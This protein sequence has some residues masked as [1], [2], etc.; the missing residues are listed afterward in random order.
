MNEYCADV[1]T[2]SIFDDPLLYKIPENLSVSVGSIVKVPFGK[3]Y[4]LGIVV[5]VRY[6]DVAT[7][8]FPIKEINRVL[9][10]N[11]VLGEDVIALIKWMHVYY[12]ATMKSLIETV[13]PSSIR[14]EMPAGKELFLSI[15]KELTFDETENLKR[16]SQKQYKI[17]DMVRQ[18]SAPIKKSDAVAISSSAC[19]A[20]IEKSYLSVITY[21]I[22]RSFNNAFIGCDYI[23]SKK[24]ILSDEQK[25]ASDALINDVLSCKFVTHVLHGVTGSG[26]TEVYLKVIR[27]VLGQNGQVIYLVPELSLTPQTVARIRNSLCLNCDEIVIWHSGLSDGERRDAW[28]AMSSGTARIV[29]GARS[30]IF[31]PF[32][33]LRLIIVDEE[34]ETTYKQNEMPRYNARDVAVYRAKL[35]NAVCILGSATPSLESLY[36]TTIG[37]YRVSRISQRIDGSAMPSI[38]VVNMRY[39]KTHRGQKYLSSALLN[40]IEDRLQ[41]NEQIVLFIN[42]RGFAS[43]VF[44]DCCDYVATCPHCST[45]LTYHKQHDILRCHLCDYVE[46]L[47]IKCPKCGS[48][49]I[50]HSGAGTQKIASIVKECFPDARIERM[51][52]DVMTTKYRFCEILNK[53]GHGE[54][55]ILVGTQMI[56][57]GLDFPNLTL[58]GIVNIDHAIN[59]PDFRANERVFQSIVQVSGRAGRGEKTGHVIVQTRCSDSSLIKMAVNNDDTSFL[60]TEMMA[61]R[62]FS[63]PPFSHIIR[64]IF[65]GHNEQKTKYYACDVFENIIKTSKEKFD[66]RPPSPAIISKSHDKFRYSI[67]CFTSYVPMALNIIQDAIRCSGKKKNIACVIDVDPLDMM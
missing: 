54:I 59:F 18:S 39:E 11:I 3:T 45:S 16:R 26:K 49:D 29:I 51:D 33:N 63:Y 1:I 58:V 7:I 9:Y 24:I 36:N 65:S 14:N 30:A 56:A 55:D 5:S 37:K 34:H 64:L 57:K 40:A 25:E 35:C 46:P 20:L 17:Y 48:K 38:E 41:K 10:D 21:D 28:M 19:R 15:S 6:V 23:K 44:C 52:S 13:L 60:M 47:P 8:E 32:N 31:S 43:V 62:E 42:K 4:V 67:V 50:L 2:T 27:H 53:F 22:C 12:A 61:R 66:V